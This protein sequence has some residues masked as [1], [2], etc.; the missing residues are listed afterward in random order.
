MIGPH[1]GDEVARDGSSSIATMARDKIIIGT[2]PIAFGRPASES[3]GRRASR[4]LARNP[5]A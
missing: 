3:V 4:R 1:S 2:L 5:E